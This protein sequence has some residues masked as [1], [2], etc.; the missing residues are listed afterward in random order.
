MVRDYGKE[1]GRALR[2]DYKA[3]LGARRFA[4]LVET[5]DG[6]KGVN[7]IREFFSGLGK[8]QGP[9]YM[10][11][12]ASLASLATRKETMFNQLSMDGKHIH[13]EAVSEGKM[14]HPT[15]TV[16]QIIDEKRYKLTSFSKDE[17]SEV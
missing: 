15:E 13:I 4:V 1:T 17:G 7:N 16:K 11:A 2:D 9:L 12:L 6:E 14:E 8:S 3:L 10:T 5:L